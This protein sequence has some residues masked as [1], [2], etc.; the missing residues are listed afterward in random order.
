MYTQKKSGHFKRQREIG[1]GRGQGG[2]KMT[3]RLPCNVIIH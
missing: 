3:D 1:G 2:G